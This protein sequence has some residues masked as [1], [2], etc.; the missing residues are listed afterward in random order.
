VCAVAAAGLGSDFVPPAPVMPTAVGAVG[1]VGAVVEMVGA[2]GRAVGR[3]LGG[4]RSSWRL[5]AVVTGGR[6]L[7]P[8]GPD[9]VAG[10]AVPINTSARLGGRAGSR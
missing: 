10:V 5:A 2:L 8:D 7:A 6:M 9:S 1:A 4:S 3:R